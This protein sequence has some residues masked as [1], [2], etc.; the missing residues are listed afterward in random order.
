MVTLISR[1]TF[2]FSDLKYSTPIKPFV[3]KHINIEKNEIIV[4]NILNCPYESGNINL[5][6]IRVI[7]KENHY[8]K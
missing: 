6:I 7:T 2:S 3:P 4:V 1:Q 8:S 5:P